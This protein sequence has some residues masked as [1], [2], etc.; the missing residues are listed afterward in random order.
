MREGVKIALWTH[1]QVNAQLMQVGVTTCSPT[2]ASEVVPAWVAFHPEV[3]QA[4]ARALLR[5]RAS[6]SNLTPWQAVLVEKHVS[7]FDLVS[8]SVGSVASDPSAA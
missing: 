6:S 4:L 5:L 8:A 7:A 1:P 2:T 3:S